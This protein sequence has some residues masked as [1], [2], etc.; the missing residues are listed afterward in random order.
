MIA[1]QVYSIV[2]VFVRLVALVAQAGYYY[3]NIGKESLGRE[4]NP[5]P[6]PPWDLGMSHPKPYQGN[7]CD[8]GV[9]ISSNSSQILRSKAIIGNDLLTLHFSKELNSANIF[10]FYMFL[11][12]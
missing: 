6:L 9:I 4:L 12:V 8:S 7:G 11:Y 10:S 5:R 2:V 3:Y 1:N